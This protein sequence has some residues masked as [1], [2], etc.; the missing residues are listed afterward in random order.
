[1][2]LDYLYFRHVLGVG[3]PVDTSKVE[4][5]L[6]KKT[7][8]EEDLR[9]ILDESWSKTLSG[10]KD[11]YKWDDER[12]I[13]VSKIN[14][15]FLMKEEDPIFKL[16]YMLENYKEFNAVALKWDYPANGPFRAHETVFNHYFN[17]AIHEY[18]YK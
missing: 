7:L 2:A 9:K 16:S 4:A 8:S 13:K 10:S 5:L 12:Q 15:T 17:L 6:V 14:K 1:M 11:E 3:G 18:L